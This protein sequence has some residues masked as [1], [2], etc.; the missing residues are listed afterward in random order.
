MPNMPGCSLKNTCIEYGSK[1]SDLCSPKSILADLCTD[2]P[3]MT[4]CRERYTMLCL[5]EKK[6]AQCRE[7]DNSKYFSNTTNISQLVKGIC[8]DMTMEGCETRSDSKT[9]LMK[10]YSNLCISMSEMSQCR[11]FKSMCHDLGSDF[12]YCVGDS[13]SPPSMRMYFHFGL[14]DYVLF[15]EWV[16]RSPL[17]YAVTFIAIIAMGILYELLL[18]LR[19]QCEANWS[20]ESVSAFN[21]YSSRQFRID[22]ARGG[23]QFVESTIAYLL[24]L[25]S[26]T[27]NVGLFFAVILGISIGTFLFSRFRVY[28]TT[29]RPCGC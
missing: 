19:S 28:G 17:T 1:Y 10:L 2:M 25:V 7:F 12:P 13:S 14:S 26:M 20:P 5:G 24:M 9:D 16:P 8:T 18:T 27:F 29:K 23:F 3:R 11:E 4:G 6:G 22:A 21:K 15:H